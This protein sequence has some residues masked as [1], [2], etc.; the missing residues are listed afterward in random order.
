M[1]CIQTNTGE[2]HIGLLQHS[3]KVENPDMA[4]LLIEHQQKQRPRTCVNMQ[5]GSVCNIVTYI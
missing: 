3:E 4:Y 1:Q 2:Y 5:E